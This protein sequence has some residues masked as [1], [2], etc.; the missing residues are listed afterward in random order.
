MNDAV[1]YQIRSGQHADVAACVDI[2]CAWVDETHWRS[3]PR[4]T[5]QKVRDWNGYFKHDHAWVAQSEDRIIG[6]CSRGG[7][8]IIA[9]YVAAGWRR[10]GVGKHSLDMAKAD[11][12]WISVSAYEKNTEARKFYRR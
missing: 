2:L 11:R 6:F 12:D 5:E 8:N 4:T 10:H 7:D 3:D 1:I 9:L